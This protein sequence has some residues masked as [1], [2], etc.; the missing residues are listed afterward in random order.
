[1]K[2][3]LVLGGGG[4]KGAFQ[5]GVVEEYERAG[6]RFDLYFGVSVGALNVAMLAKLGV[7]GLREAWFTI[8]EKDIHKRSNWVSALLRIAQGKK[9]VHDNTPLYHTAKR[10]LGEEPIQATVGFV[11][12]N[13]GEYASA[14]ATPKTVWAS[15][16]IP[17]LWEPV[18]GNFV[19]GG[20]REI[21][22]LAEA[23]K[24][25]P[26]EVVVVLCNRL[27]PEPAVTPRNIIEV[28]TRALSLAMN[29]IARNDIEG[30][31]RINELVKQAAANGG[32]LLKEDGTPYRYIPI[33]VIQPDEPLG[34]TID[35]DPKAILRRYHA[36]RKVAQRILSR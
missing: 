12:L 22:P 10:Y 16:T 36:G 26:D 27:D 21:T 4:A 11:N 29:E 30:F 15:S 2:R 20:V 25:N 19:D 33:T 5:V 17:V 8:K 35:F 6:Y 24:Q 23:I 14:L 9:S 28:A 3:A 32:Q 34:D 18:D 13:T 7:I 1:M 31:L